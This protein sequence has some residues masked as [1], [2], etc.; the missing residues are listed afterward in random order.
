[1]AKSKMELYFEEN[2][3]PAIENSNV[4]GF[5]EESNSQFPMLSQMT[6][7]VSTI[8]LFTVASESTFTTRGESLMHV[9]AHLGQK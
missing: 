1:M 4:L 6:R 8:S 9:A 3:C 5:W 2:K 7:D